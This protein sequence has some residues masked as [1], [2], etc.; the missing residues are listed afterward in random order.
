MRVLFYRRRAAYLIG[1]LFNQSRN[2]SATSRGI[3]PVFPHILQTSSIFVPSVVIIN[4]G[5]LT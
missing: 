4:S 2:F 1:S 5:R 3:G